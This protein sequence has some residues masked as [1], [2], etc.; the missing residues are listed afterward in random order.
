MGKISGFL[1]PNAY[2]AYLIHAPVITYLA[3]AVRGVMLY[4][5]L[6]FALV[7]PVAL[8]LCFGLSSLIRKIPYTDRVL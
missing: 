7:A 3:F 8:L 4:P 1:V 6:K 5:L 2:T